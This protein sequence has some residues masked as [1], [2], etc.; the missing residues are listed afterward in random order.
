MDLVQYLQDRCHEIAK[1]L[2]NRGMGRYCMFATIMICENLDRF[3]V[4]YSLHKFYTNYDESNTNYVS[5]ESIMIRIDYDHDIFEYSVDDEFAKRFDIKFILTATPMYE[6]VKALPIPFETIIQKKC[7][8]H[9]MLR[10]Y[11]KIS[12][13]QIIMCWRRDLLMT[14]LP[15]DL[16]DFIHVIAHQFRAMGR[17]DCYGVIN[18]YILKYIDIN[19][20]DR[21]DYEL[22][23]GFKNVISTNLNGESYAYSITHTWIYNTKKEIDIDVASII[24]DAI[25]RELILEDKTRHTYTYNISSVPM[26][27][28]TKELIEHRD[29]KKITLQ[30]FKYL[31]AKNYKA[32]LQLVE[33]KLDDTLLLILCKLYEFGPKEDN[34]QDTNIIF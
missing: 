3:G 6:K 26:F 30:V 18:G 31:R 7:C 20:E 33:E 11:K 2:Y 12:E 23:L 29:S 1:I 34:R 14:A 9:E 24:N 8:V 21:D 19:F 16:T 13:Y 28:N 17:S 5:V 32:V 22:K 10:M 27:A 15:H 4:K 25:Q